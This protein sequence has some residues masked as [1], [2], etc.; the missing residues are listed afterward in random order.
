MRGALKLHILALTWVLVPSLARAQSPSFDCHNAATPREQTICTIP[1]L[2]ALDIKLAT[3]Y[4][5]TLASLSP[6]ASQQVRSD[7]RNWLRWLDNACPAA[8]NSS[9]NIVDCL[10]E[11]YNFRLKQLTTGH[12]KIDGV[13]FYPRAHF[14]FIPGDPPSSPTSA[15]DDPNF[16]YAE[17]AWPQIDNPTSA[18]RAWNQ[19]V[20]A[21]TLKVACGS[22]CTTKPSFATATDDGG[23]IFS[24]YTL[25]A[26]NSRIITVNLTISTYGWGAAHPLSGQVFFAWWLDLQRPLKTT[27]VFASN[28]AW[29]QKLA[30]LVLAK[31]LK[32]PGPDALWKGDELEKAVT[33]GVIDPKSWNLSSQG[34]TITFGSYE[35]GPYSS[36]WP[37]ATIPWQDLAPLLN[38]TL[39]PTTLPPPIPT[40]R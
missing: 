34:L 32:D 38:P 16:G 20:Y 30:A 27:D 26:A 4:K 1:D 28:S 40:Q 15:S 5:S 37:S 3:A 19:T 14:A 31:L 22:E 8:A 25:T 2:A 17:F 21:A 24:D 35:V 23:Y 39:N 11:C 10:T 33:S 12:Q 29:Q 18:Q 13:L 6:P 9:G 36:G 7:Q